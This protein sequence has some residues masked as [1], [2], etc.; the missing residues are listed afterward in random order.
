ME[1]LKIKKVIVLP[2]SGRL[3]NQILNIIL[4]ISLCIEYDINLIKL[5][6]KPPLFYDKDF[7]YIHNPVLNHGSN[8]YHRSEILYMKNFWFYD[9]KIFK[10]EKY[11][12]KI[13]NIL[14]NTFSFPKINHFN[15]NILHIHIRSGDIMTTHEPDMVQPPCI[16]YENEIIK[17][18]W[19][20][21]IIVSEDT[22]NPCIK[23][24]TEKYD[25]VIYFGQN[26][27]EYDVNELL[28]ATNIMCGR[29]TFIPILSLF[30]PHLQKIH[31]PDDSDDFR[32]SP[33]V[34]M[35]YFLE[36]FHSEKCINHNEYKDYYNEIKK[37]G[38]WAY[39]KYIENLILTFRI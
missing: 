5:P 24:L 1:S 10:I 28:S 37:I 21:V 15:N 38:G 2:R 12:D 9:L 35:S 19:D 14:N 32:R 22:K 29:G 36:T 30:M 4:A 26:S 39:N 11:R 27:L 33:C 31:F 23:Y 7:I 16:Y 34:E 6:N 25:N 8:L 13:L 17:Q 18:K 20:K 3:G